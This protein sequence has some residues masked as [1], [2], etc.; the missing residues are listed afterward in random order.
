MRYI[1]KAQLIAKK[2]QHRQNPVKRKPRYILFPFKNSRFDETLQN[3]KINS[4]RVTITVC[5]D[6][7][8]YQNDDSIGMKKVYDNNISEFRN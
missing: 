3:R 5:Y 1:I 4:S 2:N 8:R 7:D 6:K